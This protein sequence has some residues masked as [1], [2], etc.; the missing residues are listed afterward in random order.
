MLIYFSFSSLH[1][2]LVSTSNPILLTLE[3][4]KIGHTFPEFIISAVLNSS[5]SLVFSVISIGN[6]F[7]NLCLRSFLSSSTV[8]SYLFWG[9]MSTLVTITKKGILRK[10]QSPMCSLVIFC[11]PMLAPTTTQ[12][13]S[14][15][16]PV[17][18]LMVVLRYFSCPQRST[19]DIILYD[20]VTTSFQYLF[21]FWLNL[22]GSTCLPSFV[23]PMIYWPIELV[24]PLCCSCK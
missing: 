22:S 10:R 19:K 24:R 4:G 23:N 15:T 2:K 8:Y 1:I 11:R 17:S 13:K 16:S 20:C 21:L 5:P 3:T 6:L 14:G 9:A 18:P 12:P 7:N